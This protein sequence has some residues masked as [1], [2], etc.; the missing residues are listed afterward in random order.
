MRIT[1]ILKGNA[2]EFQTKNKISL[3][4]I[5]RK[6]LIINHFLKV[7]STAIFKM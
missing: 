5:N 7:L 2:E 3:V 6:A 1:Q 4:R